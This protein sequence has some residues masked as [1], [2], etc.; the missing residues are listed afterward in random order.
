[1]SALRGV[2]LFVSHGQSVA[3]IGSSGSGKSTLLHLLGG[4]DRPT[5]GK[6]F[7][8]GKDIYAQNDE[9]LSLFRRRRVG[10]VF[11]AYNL[12]PHLSVY[13]N[14]VLPLGLDGRKADAQRVGDLIELLGL[15]DKRRSLPNQLSGSPRLCLPT[16]RRE[17]SIRERGQRYS[18]FCDRRRISS[19]RRSSSSRTM[20]RWRSFVTASCT[21][22]MG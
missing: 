5:A 18:T 22:R 8:E 6:V 11:Q 3:V 7:L 1:M 16:S 21:S 12:M 20:T 2:N 15:T 9:Q 10:F 14:I 13:E 4:I 17:I 19:T